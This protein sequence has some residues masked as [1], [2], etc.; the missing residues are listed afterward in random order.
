VNVGELVV[1]AQPLLAVRLSCSPRSDVL[2]RQQPS[3]RS[4]SGILGGPSNDARLLLLAFIATLL[5]YLTKWHV[6]G[7]EHLTGKGRDIAG[8][9]QSSSA[10]ACFFVCRRFRPRHHVLGPRGRERG[11]GEYFMRAGRRFCRLFRMGCD[12]LEEL[13]SAATF[14]RRNRVI[15]TSGYLY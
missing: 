4:E 7:P 5:F 10:I 12:P 15:Y 1:G 6:L 9:A 13:H 14:L 8:K 3:R 2:C 11:D